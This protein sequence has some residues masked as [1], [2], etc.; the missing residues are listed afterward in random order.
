VLFAQEWN[1]QYDVNQV[2]SWGWIGPVAVENGADV[3]LADFDT[4]LQ[5]FGKE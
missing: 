4:S 2:I 1:T 3:E 5:G